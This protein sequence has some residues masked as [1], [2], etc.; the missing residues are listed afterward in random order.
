MECMRDKA[1]PELLFELL[2]THDEGPRK[3]LVW[4]GMST[5]SADFGM[6]RPGS[7][8]LPLLVL[9]TGDAYVRTR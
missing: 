8:I 9:S 7:S 6:Y 3:A 2:N 1:R 5:A 4:R